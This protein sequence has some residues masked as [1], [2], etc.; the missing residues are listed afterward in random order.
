MKYS[1]LV[2]LSITLALSVLLA[3]CRNDNQAHDAKYVFLFI[4]DGMG[5]EQVNSTQAYLASLEGYMG[6]TPINFTEFPSLGLSTTFAHN[7]Y[8]TGSAEAGTAL[9]SGSKT[10]VGTIGLNANH[11]D[12]LFSIAY[13]LN[14]LG[15][16]VG[17]T[18]CVSIDHATPA[19]FYAH[20]PSR[21]NYHEIGHDLVSSG[22]RFFSGGSFLDPEGINSDAPRGNV[23]EVG[24]AKGVLFTHNLAIPCTVAQQHPTLVYFPANNKKILPYRIDAD[25]ASVTLAQTTSMAIDILKNPKGFFLMV[26][27]G[28]IDWACHD[29]DAATT[30]NE[31]IA[32]SDAVEVALDF[33]RRYPN[34]TLIVVTA[35]HETGGM[36]MG[37]KYWD[38]DTNIK[39][40]SHQKVSKDS[41]SRIIAD[42][43]VKNPSTPFDQILSILKDNVG[44]GNPEIE[45]TPDEMKDLKTAYRMVFNGCKGSDNNL[46][47][48]YGNGCPLASTAI[49]LLNR[50]AGI[51]W[52]SFSHT[53]SKVPVHAIGAGHEL[54]KGE[55]DNTDIP[56]R[57][58]KAM[59]L[60]F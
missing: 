34:R 47:T 60:D 52:T 30:V 27:G 10:S 14:K 9:A 3:S 41:L 39:L 7:R 8:I 4:G 1:T 49:G 28:K 11:T 22:F 26:E 43:K 19:A 20:Q 18:T 56:K 35:D 33:Y 2:I 5:V 17:I 50:R 51:G 24:E 46:K 15:Y 59:G 54:F 32:L 12:S 25:T 6:A 36:A 44:I 57:I 16:M 40:L 48:K 37:N 55:M 31:V 21:S 42:Q 13:H 29:N 45:L 23:F 38:Y 53:A 58:R